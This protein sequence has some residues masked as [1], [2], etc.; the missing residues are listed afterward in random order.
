MNKENLLHLNE[1]LRLEA[2]QSEI[3]RNLLVQEFNEHGNEIQ[4]YLNKYLNIYLKSD[5]EEQMMLAELDAF[6]AYI[7]D[8]ESYLNARIN[9]FK[10]RIVKITKLF[11][12]IG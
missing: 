7:K 2:S 9:S 6:H 1:S 10:E 8:Y 4:T 11:G 5:Q 3:N 12:Q